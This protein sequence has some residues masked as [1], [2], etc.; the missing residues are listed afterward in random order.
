MTKPCR[1]A[2]E[3]LSLRQADAPVPIFTRSTTSLTFI[4][5]LARLPTRRD[6]ACI[7]LI[8]VLAGAALTVAVVALFGRGL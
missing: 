6:I 2:P 3:S 5:Q 7:A 8:A 4:Q 1:P